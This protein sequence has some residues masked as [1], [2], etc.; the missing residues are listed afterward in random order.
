MKEQTLDLSHTTKQQ[1]RRVHR[2]LVS[3]EPYTDFLPAPF[4]SHLTPI[5]S[6]LWGGVV[7]YQGFGLGFL[8]QLLGP[9]LPSPLLGPYLPRLYDGRLDDWSSKTFLAL[10]FFE[11]SLAVW[12]RATACSVLRQHR[13]CMG[14]F[15][16]CALGGLR[17]IVFSV[18]MFLRMW[19]L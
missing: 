10:I 19:F 17:L 6:V 9:G 3:L 15:C 7:W 2:V 16:S 18:G 4:F 8:T 5:N 11:G 1:K 14:T 13:L 12:W